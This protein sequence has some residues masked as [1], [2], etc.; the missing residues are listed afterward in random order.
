MLLVF[1]FIVFMMLVGVFMFKVLY[2]VN[3]SGI[4]IFCREIVV[5]L[6]VMDDIS[7]WMS[8]VDIGLFCIGF[9]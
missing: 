7:A 8:I 2:V 6:F 3:V 1:F 4:D 9:V 5:F